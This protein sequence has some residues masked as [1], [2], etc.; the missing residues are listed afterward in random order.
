MGERKNG[1][2]EGREYIGVTGNGRRNRGEQ[3]VEEEMGKS[4]RRRKMSEVN[5]VRSGE[6]K[7]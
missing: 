2:E 5:G 1:A 7:K 6:G 4:E 3:E